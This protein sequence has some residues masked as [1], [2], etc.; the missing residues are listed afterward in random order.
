MNELETKV[1]TMESLKDNFKSIVEGP[2]QD[3]I[4]ET[5][6]EGKRL[7]LDDND[8]ELIIADAIQEL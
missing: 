2:I 7:G 8:I 3:A 6:E 4:K 1:E 5:K